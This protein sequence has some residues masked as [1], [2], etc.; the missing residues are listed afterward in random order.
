M[1]EMVAKQLLDLLT[2]GELVPGDKLPPERELA[3]QLKVGR[4][5]VREALKL[6]TLSGLLEARR[7]DGTYVRQDFT[8]FILQQIS[9]PVLLNTQ[10]IEM[11]LEVR[12]PIEVQAASLAAERITEEELNKLIQSMKLLKTKNAEL[13]PEADLEFHTLIAKASHNEVL[14]R[15]MNSLQSILHQYIELSAQ[16]TTDHETTLE[17]HQRIVDAICAHDPIAAAAA[18]EEHISISRVL[19]MSAFNQKNN[20]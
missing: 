17:E 11:V 5:T 20:Q 12:L 1:T 14:L 4:T 7:G 19:I 13:D 16:N 3:L 18:M 2:N 10:Q 8:S 9:W 6:L 15:L